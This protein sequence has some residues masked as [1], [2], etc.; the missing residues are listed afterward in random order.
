MMAPTRLAKLALRRGALAAGIAAAL[1]AQAATGPWPDAFTLAALDGRSGFALNGAAQL[2]RAGT[3]ARGAGDVNGDGF[4]DVIVGAPYA[5]PGGLREA[6]I[7]YVVFGT[8]VTPWGA[9][10]D[11]GDLDGTIGFALHGVAAG[12]RAGFVSGA[13]DINGDGFDDVA[14]GAPKADPAGAVFVVFGGPGVGAGGVVE[15]ADLDGSNGFVV[16]GREAGDELGAAVA[17]AGDVD[18][19]GFDD[20]LIGAPDAD[21]SGVR[22]GE[23]YVVF[24]AAH[25]GAG[26]EIDVAT[27][28]G[29][30]GFALA[31]EISA[32]YAGIAV[33]GAGDFNG[34]AFADILV[35]ARTAGGGGRSYVV[36]GA[37][38]VGSGG[39][40]P[41]ASLDGGN[42]FEIPGRA[43]QARAYALGGAGDVNGDG[44]DDLVIGAPAA[45]A[46]GVV[47]AGEAYVVFGSAAPRDA[48][49]D[50]DALDGTNGFV[51]PGPESAERLGVSVAIAGD[52]DGDGRDDLLIGGYRADPHDAQDAGKTYV[53]FG[54]DDLGG[55]GIF[56][57]QTLDGDN[58]FV[59]EGVGPDDRIGGAVAGAGD[60]N[61]DGFA[62]VI[63]GSGSADPEGVFAAGSAFVLTDAPD[64]DGDGLLDALDNCS[65]I[66]NPDQRDTNGD[67]YGNVCD[68]DLDGNGIVNFVDLGMFKAE[69]LT[70]APD[71]DF[72]GNGTVNFEDLGVVKAL[73]LQPPGPSGVAP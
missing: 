25:V 36:F 66:A 22:A 17:S 14:I 40:L 8:A 45:Q 56:D 43:S 69:F 28:D 50:L 6:G 7:S 1:N 65:L 5:S 32:D 52:I 70:S 2:D 51:V 37:A 47:G 48:V 46:N 12:D 4:D 67:G 3:S 39:S 19:D 31:G 71:A 20:L 38:D 57:V 58:G 68:P 13:G 55:D 23:A 29:D 49:F 11:L 59:V 21:G 42:G 10:L 9:A 62:D 18:G 61:G 27:L 44:L 35:G 41:L 26:G 30:D 15:L 72:D 53:V 34:D 73:F 33:A 16:L 60:V 63:L 24:G 54:A 64:S